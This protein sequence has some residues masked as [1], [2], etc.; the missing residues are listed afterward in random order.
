MSARTN[1]MALLAAIALP[2]AAL[3]QDA[4]P[5]LE[6]AARAMGSAALQSLR[7]SGSGSNYPLGQAYSTG[8]PWP[9]FTVKKYTLLVNYTVPAMRQE[10]VRI[11]DQ[12]PPRG[13]GAGPF[14][15]ATGQIGRAHV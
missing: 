7:V 3:A 4:N 10:L 15:A 6:A 8:G 11:D 9:R 13:G 14:V 5:T 2:L 1:A 12:S